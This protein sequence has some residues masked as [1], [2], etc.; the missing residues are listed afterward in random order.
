MGVDFQHLRTLAGFQALSV[1]QGILRRLLRWETLR[2][3]RRLSAHCRVHA[4]ADISQLVPGP[5]PVCLCRLP[6]RE[7]L[8]EEWKNA[9]SCD[10]PEHQ[11][12]IRCG[13]P[14]RPHPTRTER[15]S[16]EISL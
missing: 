9:C 3:E 13:C 4:A 10:R 11:L 8:I 16:I 7:P 1:L 5:L 6:L 2:H 12:R 14:R 15:T